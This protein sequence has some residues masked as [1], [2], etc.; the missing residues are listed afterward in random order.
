MQIKKILTNARLS[1]KGILNV[2]YIST[3]L[4]PLI[5]FPG[6]YRRAAFKRGSRLF[7]R[8]RNYSLEISKLCNFFLEITKKT[9]TTLY[10]VIYFRIT[11][12]FHIF[13]VRT[14]VL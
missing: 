4:F 6:A 7:Q 11:S 3:I 9:T 12:Y 1:V 14:L 2:F 10:S 13:I 5:S 8:M